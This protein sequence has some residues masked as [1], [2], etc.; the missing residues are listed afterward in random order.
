MI[1]VQVSSFFSVSTRRRGEPG[2]A[3]VRERAGRC[4][5]RGR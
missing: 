2:R 4:V 3:G 1:G 5:E